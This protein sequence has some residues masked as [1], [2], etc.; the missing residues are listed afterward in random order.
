MPRLA[1]NL[2]FLFTELPLPERIGAA[3]AAGFQGAETLFP[4]EC[5]IMDFAR[6]SP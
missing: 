6:S 5:E 3:A 4:Y 2:S 1:A